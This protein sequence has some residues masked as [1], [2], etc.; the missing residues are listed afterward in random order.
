MRRF[1]RRFLIAGLLLGGATP[2]AAQESVFNLPSFGLPGTG[3]SIRARG[4]GG[5]AAGLANEIFSV[6]NPAY[7]ARFDRAGFYASL[8]G[9]QGE[10]DSGDIQHEFDDVVFPMGQA[11][12]PTLYGSVLSVGFSQFVDFDA[13]LES[14]VVFEGDS[15]PATFDSQGGLFVVSPTLSYAIN[16]RTS[17]G[18]SLDVYLG[19]RE[20]IRSVDT[21]DRVGVLSTTSDSLTRD[22]RA[23][24]VALGVHHRFGSRG[25]IGLA[26]RIRPTVESEINESSGGTLNGERTD[27]DLPRSWVI[28]GSYTVNEEVRAAAILRGSSW[29]GFAIDGV[30]P[31]DLEDELEFGIGVEYTPRQSTAFVIGPRSP[32]RAG[33]R[34]RRLP[35]QVDEEAVGEWGA[36]VGYS[37]RFGVRSRVDLLLEFGRRGSVDKNGLRESFVR[38]G[39][40]IGL[41][42]QWRRRTS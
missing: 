3:Q 19:S 23:Q 40:G 10:I 30:S 1:I 25:E 22:F 38:L 35:V 17:V 20:V 5:A 4:I 36:T 28:D 33:M 39:V 12:F 16:E 9:Q 24:G 42:E 27:F 2:A 31:E 14:T 8:L 21:P 32:L 37:R 11:V 34:W 41:F 18:V 13:A 7:A 6:D 29:S 26:Y 15:L